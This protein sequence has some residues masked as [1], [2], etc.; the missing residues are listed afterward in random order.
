MRM[1]L[2]LVV[3][4]WPILPLSAQDTLQVTRGTRLRVTAE[5]SL[6]QLPAGTYRA[7][8]DTTLVLS[9]GL[10][11]E[12]TGT[13]LVLVSGSSTLRFPLASVAEVE[14]SR[15]RRRSVPGG[16]I[17]FVL[18]GAT[19]TALACLADR[20]S[21]GGPCLGDSDA[22]LLLGA[23]LGGTAGALLGSVLFGREEWRII[24]LSHLLAGQR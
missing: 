20:D 7:L 22:T 16:V 12:L 13:A 5:S 17:G 23:A 3:A 24:D 10:F 21:Y 14:G 11:R 15:G 8:D 4:G 6:V 19:G 18:G 1:L 2:A 9:T